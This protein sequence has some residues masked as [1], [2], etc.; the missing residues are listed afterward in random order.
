VRNVP[1]NVKDAVYAEYGIP[2][3]EP[4]QYEVDHLI[5]LEVGGAND[6]ANLWPEAAEPTPGYHQKDEVENYL[7]DQIC[8]GKLPLQQAQNEVAADWLAVFNK[9]P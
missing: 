2:S 5:P 3:H 8:S 4:G 1:Q 7:H 6:I 9:L